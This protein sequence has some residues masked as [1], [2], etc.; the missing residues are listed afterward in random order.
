M[1]SV[2]DIAENLEAGGRD[3][4]SLPKRYADGITGFLYFVY[5]VVF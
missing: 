3:A 4:E 1:A 2:W 5:C